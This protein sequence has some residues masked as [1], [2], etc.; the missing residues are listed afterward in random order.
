MTIDGWQL[1]ALV[2]VHR[3]GSLLDVDSLLHLAFQPV[4]LSVYDSQIIHG[5]TVTGGITVVSYPSRFIKLTMLLESNAEGSLRLPNVD[6][7]GVVVTRDV[8][9]GAAQ[10]LL[11][12]FVPG[13]YEH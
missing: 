13:V 4:L 1:V 3:R 7:E 2:S 5:D 6:V 11:G 9:D 10:F 8:V 12:S